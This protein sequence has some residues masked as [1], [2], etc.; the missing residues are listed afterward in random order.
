MANVTVAPVVVPPVAPV[1]T[2]DAISAAIPS[3]LPVLPAGQLS[4]YDIISMSVLAGMFLTFCI[5]MVLGLYCERRK[6]KRY[7]P[8]EW[9]T[10]STPFAVPWYLYQMKPFGESSQEKDSLLSNSRHTTINMYTS[11]NKADSKYPKIK[12]KFPY[13]VTIPE[14]EENDQDTYRLQGK[15]FPKSFPHF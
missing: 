5:F 10:S 7:N 14:E 8:Y 12:R 2:E 15:M 13:F 4:V 9:N 1:P 6:R 3:A 11:K